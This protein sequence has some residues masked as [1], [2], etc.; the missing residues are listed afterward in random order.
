MTSPKYSRVFVDEIIKAKQLVHDLVPLL[1][2]LVAEVVHGNAD[3]EIHQ[4]QLYSESNPAPYGSAVGVTSRIR[5]K[6]SK[7]EQDAYFS[8]EEVNMETRKTASGVAFEDIFL[9]CTLKEFILGF[10]TEP[11]ELV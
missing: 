5:W 7:D 3:H 2:N 6:E 11:F 8:F 10:P 1:D 9:C 4:E